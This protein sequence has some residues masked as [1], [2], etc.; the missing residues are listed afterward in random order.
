MAVFSGA[1]VGEG[2]AIIA[3]WAE[4]VESGLLD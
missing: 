2:V 1:G 3:T 4:G